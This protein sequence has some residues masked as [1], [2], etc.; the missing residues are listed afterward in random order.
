MLG[1][2]I[3]KAFFDLWDNLL[4]VALLNIGF[5]AITALVFSLTNLLA[6]LDTFLVAVLIP[7]V[8]IMVATMY[9]GG[10]ALTTRDMSDYESF[11]FKQTLRYFR[12][13]LPA[14]A[15]L[16]AIYVAQFFI[17]SIAVPF[18]VQID[19]LFGL[20]A[21]VFL[22]WASVIWLLSSQY[23]FPIRSR[24]DT[25]IK[26]IL[27]KCFIMFFDNTGFSLFVAIGAF[28]LAAVSLPL[29]LLVP[30]PAGVMLWIQSSFKV[31]LL[32]YDYL[33]ENQD[34]NRRHIP[35]DS[36]LVDEEQR[37]GK[38]T[39]RGMIFPWKE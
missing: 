2:T 38:R 24:L 12:Q 20:T 35:W 3:K 19:N 15:V 26:K 36:L 25:S 28:L 21:L 1:F 27:K 10:V 37:V 29:A 7:T 30:G 23:Y 14:S 4:P 16:G 13:A 5:I 9:L 8:M 22:F 6:A 11:E 31:R 34:A 32:K 33:E 17:T 39:L 18:Y